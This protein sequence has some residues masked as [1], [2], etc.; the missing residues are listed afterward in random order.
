MACVAIATCIWLIDV[1]RL[2]GWT[3]PFVVFGMNPI[4]AFVGSGMMARLMASIIKVERDGQSVSLQRAIYDSSFASW[5]APMNASLLYALC[6]VSFWFLIL[7]V[8]Y[9]KGVFL[10]V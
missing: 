7:W 5:L 3:K 10:K 6:F 4:L 1:R 9:R 2:A 8:L